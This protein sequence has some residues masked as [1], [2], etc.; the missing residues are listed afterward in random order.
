M[1]RSTKIESRENRNDDNLCAQYNIVSSKRVIDVREV[2]AIVLS[3]EVPPTI[4]WVF[5]GLG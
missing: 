2:V 3:I 5:R 1:Q 4:V